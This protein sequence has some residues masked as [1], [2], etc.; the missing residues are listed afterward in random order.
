ML[1]NLYSHPDGGG[2]SINTETHC[3]V[4]HDENENTIFLPIGWRDLELLGQGCQE[5]SKVFIQAQQRGDNT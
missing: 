3:L 2:I 4:I 1:I 5:L